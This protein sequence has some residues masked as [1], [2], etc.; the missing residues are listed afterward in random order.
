[1]AVTGNTEPDSFERCTVGRQQV[2]DT[3][4]NM[5]NLDFLILRKKS[6]TMRM[7]KHWHTLPRGAVQSPSIE[8]LKIWWHGPVQPALADLAVSRNI[9]LD[10]LQRC[11]PTQPFSD[12]KKWM[13]TATFILS[14]KNYEKRASFQRL[15]FQNT[16]NYLDDNNGHFN[17]LFRDKNICFKIPKNYRSI[18]PRKCSYF[19]VSIYLALRKASIFKEFE[20]K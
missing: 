13:H 1:M 4:W 16:S 7:V 19:K 2:R 11:F 12:S 6:L 10:K 3:S 8:I 18:Y 15:S 20:V 9:G 17:P 14:G 5:A